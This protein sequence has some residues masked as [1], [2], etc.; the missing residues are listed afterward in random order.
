MRINF[1]VDKRRALIQEEMSKFN[2]KDYDDL[3]DG[4][5]LDENDYGGDGDEDE[6]NN[7]ENQEDEYKY[8]EGLD[9]EYINKI[10]EKVDNNKE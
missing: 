8:D 4:D 3:L 10:I 5:D 1:E 6:Y 2:E 7:E 9:D